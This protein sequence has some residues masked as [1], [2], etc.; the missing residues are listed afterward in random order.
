MFTPVAYLRWFK[1]PHSDSERTGHVAKALFQRDNS[2]SELMVHCTNKASNSTGQQLLPHEAQKEHRETEAANL[3]H[4]ML[5][6]GAIDG[7]EVRG[8]TS[9]YR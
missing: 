5:F 9:W 2:S 3:E 8:T 6:V 7:K 1:F 4:L